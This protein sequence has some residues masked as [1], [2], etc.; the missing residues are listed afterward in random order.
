MVLAVFEYPNMQ[1]ATQAH[2]LR[3]AFVWCL[4][5]HLHT[6]MCKYR[7]PSNCTFKY[8]HKGSLY[9]FLIELYSGHSF[10]CFNPGNKESLHTR[11]INYVSCEQQK[12]LLSS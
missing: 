7:Q 9:L 5:R 2:I 8:A 12:S 4:F 1:P 3:P 10:V 6:W 11:S